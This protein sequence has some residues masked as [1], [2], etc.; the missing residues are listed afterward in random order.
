[1]KY[2]VDPIRRTRE[3][4]E[5]ENVATHRLDIPSDERI[6]LASNKRAYT[7]TLGE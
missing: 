6:S 5:I 4:F 3:R 1:M 7:P 2:D